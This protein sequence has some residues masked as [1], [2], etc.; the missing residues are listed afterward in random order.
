MRVTNCTEFEQFLKESVELRRPVENAI[1]RGHIRDCA[2]CEQLWQQFTLLDQ[3]IPQWKSCL[4][5]VDLTDAVLAQLAFNQSF[6]I[7]DPSHA[8]V[9]A[10]SQRERSASMP[11]P[12]SRNDRPERLRAVSLVRRNNSGSGRSVVAVLAVVATVLLLISQPFGSG[13]TFQSNTLEDSAVVRSRRTIPVETPAG[14]SATDVEAI[15][16][17]AGSA[18]LVL[19]RN[20][21][22]VFSDAVALIPKQTFL[23]PDGASTSDSAADNAN[24]EIPFG[25]QL[26]PIGRD[27]EHAFDFLFEAILTGKEPAT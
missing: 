16:R 15:V 25:R 3:T 8:D 12:R 11:D 14:E 17:D 24:P 21:A 2:Q 10:S 18:Y 20:T 22:D 9:V 26:K 7:N 27:V 1:V 19:A 4:P 6:E 5:P 13:T 23:Q